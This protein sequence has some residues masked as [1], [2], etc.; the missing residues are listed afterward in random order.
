MHAFGYIYIVLPSKA[1]LLLEGEKNQYT[2]RK[3]QS[4]KS[5]MKQSFMKDIVPSIFLKFTLPL[6]ESFSTNICHSQ[7]KILYIPFLISL[8]ELAFFPVQRLSL[9]QLF[10]LAADCSNGESPSWGVPWRNTLTLDHFNP[11]KW[12]WLIFLKPS[13]IYFSK[14]SRYIL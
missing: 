11:M 1:I 7:L 5:D 4:R 10:W 13:F 2:R 12:I 6:W 9:E 8:F 3:G 14:M